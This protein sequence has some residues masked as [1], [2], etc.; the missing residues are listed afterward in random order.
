MFL[1][2]NAVSAQ[3]EGDVRDSKDKGIPKALVIAIDSAGHTVDSART[4]DRGFYVFNTLKKG[5]Y[6]IEVK[7]IGF[8]SAVFENI[9]V[10][11]DVSV[12]TDETKDVSNATRLDINLTRVKSPK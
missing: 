11:K 5:S 3:I 8:I 4:D 12:P 1:Y 7:A 10:I 9:K 2:V 6:K